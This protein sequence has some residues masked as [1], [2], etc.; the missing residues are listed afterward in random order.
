M[1]P[2]ALDSNP[3]ALSRA[4]IGEAGRLESEGSSCSLL[5]N[6]NDRIQLEGLWFLADVRANEHGAVGASLERCAL[7]KPSTAHLSGQAR[8]N[9]SRKREEFDRR[10]KAIGY[11]SG[12]RPLCVT[13]W[14][15]CRHRVEINQ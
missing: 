1:L 7:A 12:A 13:A 3:G 4:A 15:L 10:C 11:F 9:R 2:L 8:D 5:G 6:R 14:C